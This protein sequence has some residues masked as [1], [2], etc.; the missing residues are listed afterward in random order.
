MITPSMPTP[1]NTEKVI[2][3]EVCSNR[4][5]PAVTAIRLPP[6]DPAVK[7]PMSLPRIADVP[8]LKAVKCAPRRK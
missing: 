1:A 4:A 8:T 2:P 3:L 5:A 6:L 7:K